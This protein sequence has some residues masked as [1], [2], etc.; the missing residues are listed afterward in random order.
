MGKLK[1]QGKLTSIVG[2]IKT[3]PMI[4]RTLRYIFIELKIKKNPYLKEIGNNLPID[5]PSFR[6][7]KHWTCRDTDVII[8]VPPKSGTTWC[9]QICQQ[10]R[11]NGKADVNFYQDLEDVQPWLE[12]IIGEANGPSNE[13]AIKPDPAAGPGALDLD[14]DQVDSHIRCFKSHL[15]LKKLGGLNCKKIYVYRH[16]VDAI[17]SAYRFM[18]RQI[19]EVADKTTPHQF[20]TFQILKGKLLQDGLENLCDF[21]DHRHDKN[22]AF[23]F[24]DDLKENHAASVTRIAEVMGIDPKPELIQKVVE[25]STVSFMSSE[26]HHIRFENIR[27]IS[28]MK[29]AVGLDYSYWPNV[30][31]QKPP[32]QSRNMKVP[33]EGGL[34]NASS[35][36]KHG[37][38]VGRDEVQACFDLSWNRIVLPRTGFRN[39]E[40][41]RLAWNK[42]LQ[43]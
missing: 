3:L 18:C 14:V 33:K 30:S 32:K 22:I 24:Y 41:M 4:Y 42:E 38:I 17:Y 36:A 12:S 34:G 29:R 7:S 43:V 28:C 11:V 23:F 9:Q 16:N 26:D 2:L 31:G 6:L 20:A 19:L 37:S 25:Q 13:Y 27:G 1:E 40:E 35:K 10:L 5:D 8:A 21:W 15:G 39:L